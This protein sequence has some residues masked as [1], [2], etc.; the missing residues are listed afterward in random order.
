MT[1]MTRCN[2]C[3]REISGAARVCHRCGAMMCENCAAASGGLCPNCY[4]KT[5]MPS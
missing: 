4:G 3:G 1:F 2:I 5:N